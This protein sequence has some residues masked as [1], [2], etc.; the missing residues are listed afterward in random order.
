MEPFG[1]RSLDHFAAGERADLRHEPFGEGSQA[2]GGAR[3][4]IQDI[5]A[6][7]QLIVRQGLTRRG[8]VVGKGDSQHDISWLDFGYLRDISRDGKTILFEEEGSESQNY[9]VFV[10]DLDG[11]A[12][13]PIGDGYGVAFS[14]DKRWALAQKIPEP[15]Q[16]WLLPLG[17]GEAKR[18]N[19]PNLQAEFPANFLSDGRRVIYAA[20]EAGHRPRVWLQDLGGGAPRSV[21]DEGLIGWQISADDKW[22]VTYAYDNDNIPR[23]LAMDTG[24]SQEMP[25]IHR[26]QTILGWTSD[27]QLYVMTVPTSARSSVHIDKVNPHTGTATPWRD[28]ALPSIEGIFAEA[29]VITPDGSTFGYGYR[30]RA[31]DLY[32]VNGVR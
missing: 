31:W 11:S 14:P 7:G 9:T 20:N 8:M 23:L 3:T 22:L 2:D 1:R 13:T 10:R 27:G 32:T 18:I 4:I 30:L 6:N 16:L 15:A 12:A 25:F 28:L 17:P 19:P 5:A 24:K 26:N 29:P 21:T